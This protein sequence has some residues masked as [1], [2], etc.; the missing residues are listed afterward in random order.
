MEII[1]ADG[2]INEGT[3]ALAEYM[4]P[5]FREYGPSQGF[6]SYYPSDA[7]D[8]SVRGSLG[9]NVRTPEDW[10][11]AMKRGPMEIAVLFPTQGLS[12][13]W[14][15]ETDFAGAL[16]R[17]Y[18]DFFHA[19]YTRRDSRLRGIALLPMQD[20]PAAVR[21]LRRA[22]DQL[23]MVGAMLPSVGLRHPLGH[24]IYW[25]VYAEAERLGCMLASHATVRGPQY[26]GAD[27]FDNFIEVHTLSH[28]FAQMTQFASMIF[29]GV[30][31]Q[32]PKLKLGFM[33]A[34]CTWAP[35]WIDR[36]NEEWE[37]RGKLEA[38]KCRRKP[39]DYL[40][41]GNIYFGLEA[42]E[43]SIAEMVRRFGDE[44]LVFASDVPHWDSEYPENIHELAERT[45]LTAQ[46][47][48]KLFAT[49]ARTLYGLK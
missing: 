40:R 12:I 10:L 25:P 29:R 21:E 2:H 33:E 3:T 24:E 7:W 31:E 48:Q 20:V 35:F 30:P 26:F 15:R 6:R 28:A 14:I 36:M 39:S 46:T 19:Q 8:R 37:L 42:G 9:H 49:N 17:A 11:E 5:A 43:Q 13:G 32:F 41:Q 47:K 38:P 27:I 23:G 18:N 1:D 34:G 45:D 22:V 16:C 4:D 44:N